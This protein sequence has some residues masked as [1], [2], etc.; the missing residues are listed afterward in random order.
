MAGKKP[1]KKNVSN[2]P[3]ATLKVEQ[4]GKPI[5]YIGL[6]GKSFV[7]PSCSRELQRGMVYEHNNEKFCSRNCIV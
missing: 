3:V 6:K 2:T 4:P 7:C 5:L 1:A